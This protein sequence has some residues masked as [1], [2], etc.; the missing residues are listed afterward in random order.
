MRHFLTALGAA[1]ASADRG[2]ELLAA[3]RGEK[4]RKYAE[5]VRGRR[6]KL[7]V[8]AL[9]TGGRWSTEALGFVHTLAWA[10]A[11]SVPQFLRKSA[12]FSWQR[13]WTRMLS[14]AAARA[15]AHGLNAPARACPLVQG[16]ADAEL[17]D[18]FGGRDVAMG[19]CVTAGLGF[20]EAA[21]N[22]G[23]DAADVPAGDAFAT[24]A[25]HGRATAT[26][27]RS[28]SAGALEKAPNLQRLRQVASSSAVCTMPHRDLPQA[29]A[30]AWGD[31]R[32]QAVRG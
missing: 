11:R 19:F 23:D 1:R 10:K 17:C 28:Y 26:S 4:E 24:V 13:R 30:L 5:L 8:L 6:C 27:T 7:I 21:C 20:C 32:L 14:V 25:S 2:E 31:E 3:A 29:R 15:F 22:V 9:S 12:A 16:G 18:L